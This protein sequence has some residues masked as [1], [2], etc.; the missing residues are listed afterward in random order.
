MYNACTSMFHVSVHNCVIAHVLSA[1]TETT[2]LKPHTIHNPKWIF[3]VPRER[4]RSQANL[5]VRTC[6]LTWA[7]RHQSAATVSKRKR[8]DTQSTEHIK[9]FD[10]DVDVMP[11]C[12]ARHCDI[13]DKQ[14]VAPTTTYAALAWCARWWCRD[15]YL[16]ACTWSR[17]LCSVSANG[18]CRFHTKSS[19]ILFFCFCLHSN[20]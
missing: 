19:T 1:H 6:H 20:V 3:D 9:H 18:S 8:Y 4:E 17:C 7:R 12:R 13:D 16:L 14:T 11:R 2:R 15:M 5:C 10:P